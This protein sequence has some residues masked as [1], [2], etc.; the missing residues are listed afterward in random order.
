M[1]LAE[2]LGVRPGVTSVIGS[3]GKTSL[4][5]A[6]ARELPGTVVLTTTTHILPFPDVPLMTSEDAADV[7]AALAASRVVCVGSQA[8]KDGKLVAPELGIDALASLADHVLVEADGAR[9]LPLKAH[10]PWEPVIPACSGRTILVLG[11]SGLGHPVR[12]KVHRPEL[13]CELVGCTPDDLATPE[14]VARA[15]N[16]EALADVALVNQ[17]DVAPDA[18]HDLAALLAIPAFVGSVLLPSSGCAQD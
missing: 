4:L 6:L 9:R 12:E 13:F 18:A 14:L 3:G 17:A 11:T 2:T 5:S 15:A 8:E 1:A 7:R 10:A 16:A